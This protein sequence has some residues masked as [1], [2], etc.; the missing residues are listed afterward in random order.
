LDAYR[1][2]FSAQDDVCLVIKDL[3]TSS[4]YRFGNYREQILAAM[5]DDAGPEIVYLE[6]SM[7]PGQLASL[8]TACECLV[9]PYRGEGSGLPILEGM[10]CGLPPIVPRGGASDDFV[11]EDTGYLLPAREVF[12]CPLNKWPAIPERPSE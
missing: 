7:S 11:T 9:T 4:F 12:Q 3:G 10:A 5:A 1:A 8:Y 6:R 2:E